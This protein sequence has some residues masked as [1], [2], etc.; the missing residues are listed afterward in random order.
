MINITGRL[1]KLN[2]ACIPPGDARA[3][4]EAIR[5]LILTLSGE[6]ASEA[7][8]SID[9]LSKIISNSIPELEGKTLSTISAQGEPVTDTGITI[10]LIERENQRKANG[11]IVG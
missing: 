4:W 7:P 9:Q 2:A 11:E 6:P 3:D 10:P 5:D 8:Q 1:Q